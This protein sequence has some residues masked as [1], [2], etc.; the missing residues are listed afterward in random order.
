M[1]DEAAL[2][3]GTFPKGGSAS[4]GLQAIHKQWA[5][6]TIRKFRFI[7]PELTMTLYGTNW[8][9]TLYVENCDDESFPALTKFFDESVR[10]MTCNISLSQ[11][12]P[13]VGVLI[14]EV[15]NY[16]EELWLNGE[17][18]PVAAGN[19]LLS[20]AESALPEGEIDFDNDQDTWVFRSFTPLRAPL[21]IL[22]F[23]MMKNG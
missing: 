6:W 15:D 9:F 11:Q 13:P 3:Q 1:V 19:N 16:E 2:T 12:I 10:P 7:H 21:K 14:E 22:L 5:L 20:L 8:K 17:P 23:R 4:K 18:L